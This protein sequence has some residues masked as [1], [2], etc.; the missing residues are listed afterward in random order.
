MTTYHRYLVTDGKA[1][2][3][4][5]LRRAV[6]AANANISF[7]HEMV[8]RDGADCGILIDVTTKGD[9]IFD[10]DLNLV[11]ERLRS[12]TGG[13]VRTR[14]LVA[15]S[16]CMVTTQVTHNADKVVLEAIWSTIRSYCPGILAM[17]DYAWTIRYYD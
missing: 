17:E 10:D 6:C 7:D 9:P 14:E 16:Q 11:L 15:S 3:F 12:A 4:D 13:D 1:T 5:E 2:T 8:L